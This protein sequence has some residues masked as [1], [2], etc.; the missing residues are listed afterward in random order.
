MNWHIGASTG[1]CVDRPILEVLD[2]IHDAGIEGVELGTPPRHF[3]PWQQSQVHAVRERLA[4]LKLAPISIHAPFGASLELSDSNP[5]HRNAALGAILTASSVLK[6]LAGSIVIV[7]ATDVPRDG[8]NV[9]QRLTTCVGALSVLAREFKHMAL[10]L[11]IETPLPHLI[12]GHPDEFEWVLRRLDSSV[13]V[14]LD[15][16]HT[17]LGRH[18]RRFV[19]VAGDRLIHVHASD[20]LGQFDDHFPPGDGTIDWKEIGDSLRQV[21]YRGWFMLELNCPS[22]PLRD[23]YGRAR[24]QLARLLD[25]SPAP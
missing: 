11:A 13:R 25:D 16:S 15:T 9:E 23:H 14:C 2:A 19:E 6:Q 18:W 1:A 7:H 21:N 12:G 4:A 3:D 22:G 10:T 17:T 20:H 8:Q 5:H 24:A